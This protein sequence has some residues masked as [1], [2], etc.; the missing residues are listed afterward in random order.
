[1]STLHIVNVAHTNTVKETSW[2]A[3]TSLCRSFTSMMT[4]IGHTTYLYAGP[5]NDARCTEHINCRGDYEWTERLPPY[6]SNHPGWQAFADI[7]IQ[8]LHQRFQPGDYLCLIGGYVQKPIADSI[9]G[10]FIVEPTVGYPGTINEPNAF[11]V[12][13]SYAWMHACY[14]QWQGAGA[15]NGL[16]YDAV[17]PH[18]VDMEN[19]P[20]GNGDGDYLLYVGRLIERKGLQIV[21]E[22]AER[23]G[24]PLVVAGWGDE[25]LIPPGAHFVGSVEPEARGELMRNARC[26]LVPTLYLEPFGLVAIEAMASGTPAITTDFGAFTETVLDDVTGYRCNSLDDFCTTVEMAKDLDRSFIRQRTIDLYSAEAVGVQYNDFFE[27]LETLKG[28]GWY[29]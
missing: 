21:R 14:G 5:E 4:D 2:C 20:E 3:F 11:H 16:F 6:E 25:S 8:E 7:A 23:T 28:P 29:A 26:L 12:Y 17:I 27:H 15:A 24:L 18:W 9:P 13:P 10:C 22:V 1:M 19:H